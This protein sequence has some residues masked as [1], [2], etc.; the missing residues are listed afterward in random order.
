MTEMTE[1]EWRA[2]VKRRKADI[3]P[4]TGDYAKAL[5]QLSEAAYKAI[6]IIELERSG[7]RDGDGFW[8]DG[9]TYVQPRDRRSH[10][11]VSTCAG[12]QR[13]DHGRPAPVG[14]AIWESCAEWER[15]QQQIKK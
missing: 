5:N 9:G 10:R 15:K 7:I 1:Q 3:E 2:E 8:H 11:V 6:K 13:R 12:H 14:R 4:A